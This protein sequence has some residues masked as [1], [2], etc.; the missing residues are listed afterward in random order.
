IQGAPAPG[1]TASACPASTPLLCIPVGLIIMAVAALAIALLLSRTTFG[2]GL[3]ATGGNDRAAQLSGVPVRT[4][5]VWVYVISGLCSAIAGLVLASTL[6]SASPNA[7]NTYELT[8]I[9]AVVIGGA[10]L[11]GGRGNVR[12]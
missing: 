2:R 12:G 3:Y 7:G 9:A 6:T 11:S 5:K 1:T 4:V 10:V 8:A